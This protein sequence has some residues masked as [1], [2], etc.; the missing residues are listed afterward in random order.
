MLWNERNIKHK[1]IKM[2]G[3]QVNYALRKIYRFK[4]F[5]FLNQE[6]SHQIP[7]ASVTRKKKEQT[8]AKTSRTQDII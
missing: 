5:E 8:N 2:Y 1:E 4:Y 6:R 7:S 3:M